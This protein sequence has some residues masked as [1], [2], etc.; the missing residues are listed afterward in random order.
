[1]ENLFL[2][3]SKV[4]PRHT[5]W[6]TAKFV[7]L[8]RKQERRYWRGFIQLLQPQYRRRNMP[9]ITWVE[10][11]QRKGFSL[12]QVLYSDVDFG[13]FINAMTADWSSYS[14][15]KELNDFKDSEDYELLNDKQRR[16]WETAIKDVV[17]MQSWLSFNA[18]RILEWLDYNTNNR[19]THKQK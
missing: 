9:W 17:E 8:I 14:Q 5:C 13:Y 6:R 1:M 16:V 12:L 11:G 4:D 10:Y 19:R 7:H 18:Q 3:R 15:L 2:I